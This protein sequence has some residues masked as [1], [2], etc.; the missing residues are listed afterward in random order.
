LRGLITSQYN[1]ND[2][3]WVVQMVVVCRIPSIDL[4]P[5]N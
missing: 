1:C 3:D 2:G 5:R 4:M